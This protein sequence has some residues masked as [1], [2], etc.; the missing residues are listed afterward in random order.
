[1]ML[2]Q[3]GWCVNILS[4]DRDLFQLV[5]DQKDIYVLYMGGGPYAKSGNPTLMNENGV[6][7]KLGVYPERVVD[8]KALT[9][10]SSDNIPGIKGVG[11][12]TAIN[13]LKENDTLDGI[14]KALDIIQKDEDKKYQGFIKGAV[15]EKLKNDK[16]NAYLSRDLAKIDVEV[17]LVLSNG[18]EL[19]Q[20]NQDALSESLQKLELST[21]LR[22]VDIFNSAFSKGGF[23]K[24][25]E[26]K[27]KEKNQKFQLQLI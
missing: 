14:Y 7:E 5:D 11:P 19:N 22:Q 25:N 16:F 13:L 24:N 17:P 3:K 20:I 4:G 12:K 26:E 27:Q 6:K 2:P 1:M 9:G 23:N 8:L 10:D 18:Y 21:L 15:R